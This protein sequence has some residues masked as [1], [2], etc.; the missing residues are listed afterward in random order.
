MPNPGALPPWA[1]RRGRLA[2]VTAAVLLAA[3]QDAALIHLLP[4]DPPLDVAGSSGLGAIGGTS[5]SGGIA[6]T[7][8]TGGAG[9]SGNA[10]GIAAGSGGA[11][12]GGSAGTGAFG[13]AAPAGGEAGV[14]SETGGAGEGHLGAA[15][16]EAGASGGTSSSGALIHRYDFS[17][18][19]TL[20]RDLVGGADGTFQNG[21]LSGLGYAQLNGVEQYVAL[22][23]GII[24]VLRNATFVMWID[25]AG[26]GAWERVFDFGN[27]DRSGV[28]DDPSDDGIS[29]VGKGI[30]TFWLTPRNIPLDPAVLP[31]EAQLG[32]QPARGRLYAHELGIVLPEGPIQVA[33]AIDA[34]AASTSV[35]LDGQLLLLA[36]NPDPTRAIDLG[37]LQDDNNWL[38]RSQ[39]IQDQVSFFAGTYDEFRI[40]AT[41]LDDAYIAELAA[42]GP[43]VLPP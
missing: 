34:D 43:D 11:S 10:G 22:P 5:A 8:N 29:E 20:V 39:W 38:G 13:A 27:N 1:I 42:L 23:A 37:A 14:A 15:G 25:W 35:Y 21:T 40:Y 41:A 12:L 33:I 19:G 31:D 18:T 24:S 6:S 16:G 28:A 9:S 26:G 3:C 32:F 2:L 30:T 36:M 4:P 7:G 17:G